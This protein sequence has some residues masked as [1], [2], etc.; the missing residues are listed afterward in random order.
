[1]AVED[2]GTSSV[3][4]VLE[5]FTLTS[6]DCS[7]SSFLVRFERTAMVFGRE[8][9]AEELQRE[10]GVTKLLLIG[11]LEEGGADLRR[12]VVE[13]GFGTGDS[14]GFGMGE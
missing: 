6:S 5:S 12:S 14:P 10:I 1:M 4:C 13:L 3:A 2:E 7:A 8:V 9:E 11:S